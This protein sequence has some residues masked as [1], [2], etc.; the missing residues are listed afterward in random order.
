LY[1]GGTLPARI[2]ALVFSTWDSY[3]SDAIAVSFT[4]TSDTLICRVCRRTKAPI[5][6]TIAEGSLIPRFTDC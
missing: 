2:C 1:I 6:I 4:L 5:A 3:P